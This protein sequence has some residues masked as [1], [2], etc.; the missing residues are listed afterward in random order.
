MEKLLELYDSIICFLYDGVVKRAQ[1][2]KEEYF[3]RFLTDMDNYIKEKQD[4][5]IPQKHS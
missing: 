3:E 4:A 5:S 2:E 1:R